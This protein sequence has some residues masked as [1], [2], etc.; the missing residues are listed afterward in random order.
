V[1]RDAR[2][3][4]RLRPH[5]AP[6]LPSP[7]PDIACDIVLVDVRL[8]F[9]TDVV[10]AAFRSDQGASR[11]LLLA[12]LDRRIVLVASVP[13]FL[14]YEAV[15]T[16]PAHLAETGLNMAE[17]NVILDALAAVIEPVTFH[18]LWKPQLRDPADEMVLETAVNGQA[19]RLVTFNIRHLRTAAGSFGIQATRP[20]EV[21]QA[22]RKKEHAKK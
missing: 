11:Q 12:A 6:F 1:A 3:F 18:F 21:L 20:G 5:P 9:D 16:R 8:M 14:E 22:L 7:R 17:T 4:L 13:L 15:L 2:T 10:V 19:D